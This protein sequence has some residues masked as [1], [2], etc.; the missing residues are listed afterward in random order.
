MIMKTEPKKINIQERMQEKAMDAYAEVEYQIDCWMDN[1]KSDF[2][3]YKYLKQLEY[4][5]KVVTFMKGHT[6]PA[7]VEVKNE[8]GCEQLEEA[9]N[10]LTKTQKKKYI[11]FLE[12]IESDIGKYCDEYKPIRRVKPMTPARM[13]R[14]LPFLA[15]WEDYKSIEPIEIPRAYDLFTYNTASKKFTHFSG[16]LAVKGSRI[17]GYDSCKEKTLTDSKLLDR[18][19][20]GGNI[21]ARGFMDEIPRSKLKDG[22]D[23]MTKNTLLLKV[24]K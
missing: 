11:K 14:K 24:I 22:N 12:S 21:I 17:T 1:K 23:M 16:N 8:E 5:G 19:V 20:R 6:E 2:S 3:M 7:L 4:S 13:V 10:F 9:F 15:E 18:L